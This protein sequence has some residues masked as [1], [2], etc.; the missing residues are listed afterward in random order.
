MSKGDGRVKNKLPTWIAICA[1]VVCAVAI[2]LLGNRLTGKQVERQRS[3]AEFAALTGALPDAAGFEALQLHESRYAVD[4]A[5][6]ARD[7]E[8]ATVGY[9]GKATVSGYGGPVEV[10]TGLDL[11][12]VIT[13]VLVGGDRF[14]E[15]PGLGALTREAAFT[16]QFV[17]KTPE[18]RL[19]QDGVDTVTGASTTSRAVISAVNRTANYFYTGELGLSQETARAAYTGQTRSTTRQGYGGEVTVTVG[20]DANDAVEYLSVDTPD[21]TDG[22]GKRCSE[23]AFTDQFIGKMAPFVYGEDGIDAV[24]GAT[25]TST[26]VLDALNELVPPGDKSLLTANTPTEEDAMSSDAG[27]IRYMRPRPAFAAGGEAKET[28]EPDVSRY[29]RPRPVIGGNNVASDAARYMRPRP[30]N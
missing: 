2:V 9:V 26:A 25:V 13:G 20:L 16:G 18:I 7:A 1:A 21:E 5:W 28:A 22:L 23:P 6:A 14:A 4:A 12:G 27:Y 17:G 11:N 15:T 29:M 8:G 10:T 24:T 30:A 3:N 19:N